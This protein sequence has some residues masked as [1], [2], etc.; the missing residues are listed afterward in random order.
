ML[1]IVRLKGKESWPELLGKMGEKA[2]KIIEREN[3]DVHTIVLSEDS[4]VTKDFR[5]N[6]VRV[7]VNEDGVVTIVPRIG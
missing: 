4:P 3:N 6:R 5:F 7:F 2:V 1:Y